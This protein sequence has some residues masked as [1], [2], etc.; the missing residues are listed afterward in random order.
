MSPSSPSPR[1]RLFDLLA[2]AV[3]ALSVAFAVAVALLLEIYLQTSPY[4]SSLLCAIMFAAWFGGVGPG[5]LAALLS[6]PTFAFVFVA[7]IGTFDVALYDTPR[8]VLFAVAALFVVA[9][10]AAQ[11]AGAASLRRARDELQ[12]ENA[13]RRR[14]EAYLE[15]AQRLSSMGSFSWKI[16]TGAVFWSKEVYEILGVD[17]A[18]KPD[19]D[20]ALRN[21]HPDDREP[22]ER[23]INR[24]L[25]CEQRY[26]FEVRWLTPS[27]SVKTLHIRAQHV[28]FE[29]GDEEVVGA[30]MDVTE[31]RRAQDALHASQAE[32]AHSTRVTTLGEMSASIAHEVNQ[33]IGAIVTNAEAGLRWLSHPEPNLDEARG[34]IDRIIRD[35]RR[36][37]EVVQRLRRLTK[38]APTQVAPVDVNEIVSDSVYLVNREILNSRIALQLEL[39]PNLPQV[40]A[41]R[42][43]LQQVVINLIVNGIQAME[44]IVDRPRS[45]VV[46]SVTSTGR[47]LVAVQDAGPG[48][49]LND[50]SRLFTPFFTTKPKGMGMGLSICRSIIESHGGRIWASNNTGL[51]STF[52]FALPSGMFKSP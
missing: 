26:D 30:L 52:H 16:G 8:I 31:T 48:V 38:K 24:A 5:A 18:L 12:H 49:N 35:G 32:L 20:L 44:A 40:L 50:M 22:L 28:N 4:V 45:L 41:D 33:P 39:A 10:A 23:E 13:E 47:V 27:A 21:I 37:S 7:P 9:L 43:E 51:G 46:R 6:I 14:I 17:K 19:I 3:A 15:E 1:L 11:S 36:A 42:I 2:Y 29:S 34:A 25:R